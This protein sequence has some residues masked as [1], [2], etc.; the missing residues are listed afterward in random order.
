MKNDAAGQT[1]S[2]CLIV[3]FNVRLYPVIISFTFQMDA[4]TSNACNCALPNRIPHS[5]AEICQPSAPECLLSQESC[6]MERARA[7]LPCC[8]GESRQ[9][10]S[11]HAVPDLGLA[12]FP[13]SPPSPLPSFLDKKSAQKFLNAI[14]HSAHSMRCACHLQSRHLWGGLIRGVT[15]QLTRPSAL[16]FYCFQPEKMPTNST[17][18][19]TRPQQSKKRL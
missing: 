13:L 11:P 8:S 3:Y 10:I 19:S 2:L 17:Q 14:K 6:W 16:C 15:R 1:V 9:C 5:V 18:H 4:P 7:G 12:S